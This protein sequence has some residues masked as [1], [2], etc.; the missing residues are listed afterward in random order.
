MSIPSFK[1]LTI[2]TGLHIKSSWLTNC[3]YWWVFSLTLCPSR[4]Q[5][6]SKLCVHAPSHYQCGK[7]VIDKKWYFSFDRNQRPLMPWLALL[8]WRKPPSHWPSSCGLWSTSLVMFG[9]SAPSSSSKAPPYSLS[10]SSIGMS[11]SAWNSGAQLTKP[12]ESFYLKRTLQWWRFSTIFKILSYVKEHL[13]NPR[14][15]THK[16]IY[17]NGFALITSKSSGGSRGAVRHF[18]L[19][20][21]QWARWHFI[22]SLLEFP[23]LTDE[24]KG[25]MCKRFLFSHYWPTKK[26]I[27]P[28]GKE[29][30]IVSHEVISQVSPAIPVFPSRDPHLFLALPAPSLWF[31]RR[32][33]LL[34]HRTLRRLQ[35][36]AKARLVWPA[37]I[38]CQQNV[39]L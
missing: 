17:S 10:N 7:V 20:K 5:R 11:L 19:C 14:E 23:C 39:Q 9:D 34:L 18:L 22:V 36:P 29:M 37:F 30:G 15:R 31:R 8:A 32:S 1:N 12:T 38:L 6:T 16:L 35:F 33:S 2:E 26:H 27:F 3:T 4:L 24:A 28:S 21:V 25:S 13:H